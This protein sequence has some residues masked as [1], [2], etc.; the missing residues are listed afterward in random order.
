MDNK[1]VRLKQLDTFLGEC[2]N[3]FALK[4]DKAMRY[5]GQVETYS[6]LPTEGNEIGDMRNIQK[7]DKTQ[8]IKAGDNVAW[9]GTEWDN[10]GGKIDLSDYA[11][12]ADQQKDIISATGA[13]DTITL[14]A[15]DGTTIPL[16][17]SKVAS[18]TQADSA[19][20][21]T[22]A[23]SAATAT[24]A[25][26]DG[27]GN[28]IT[29]TYATKATTLSG[30]GIT[31]AKIANGTITIGTNAI[32]PITSHQSLDDYAKKNTISSVGYSGSYNDLADTPTIPTKLSELTN[33]GVF[34]TEA[35]VQEMIDA[36]TSAD[37]KEY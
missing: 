21:A 17:I 15:R 20:K 3:I 24:K 13:A 35:K 7:A 6:D 5:K 31:D 34:V 9:S 8:G 26:Q 29:S 18:A 10:M 11:L 30:Y 19:T 14:I 37:G 22:S 12:S 25:T 16:T 28:V 4:G 36:I 2:K 33:D 23:D 1:V 27:N 32:T